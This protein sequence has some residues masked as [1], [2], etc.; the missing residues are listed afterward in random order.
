MNILVFGHTGFLGDKFL[1]FLNNTY[2]GT[3]VIGISIEK[4]GSKYFHIDLEE[5]SNFS[6]PIDIDNDFD[7]VFNFVHSQNSKNVFSAEKELAGNIVDFIETKKIN[8]PL[9]MLR[10]VG[11]ESDHIRS[12]VAFAEIIK[13]RLKN[14]II[15]IRAGIIEEEGSVSYEIP[16]RVLKQTR[17]IPRFPWMDNKV[18]LIKMSDLLDVFSNIIDGREK[19]NL[20]TPKHRTMTYK[21]YIK[22]IAY[23]KRI[24]V[25]FIKMPFNDFIVTPFLVKLL[26]GFDHN[27][28]KNLMNTLKND[29]VL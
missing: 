22:E 1:E 21:E 3:K 4:T 26:T 10:S 6:D 25:D 19:S 13:K 23:E 14:R 27:I 11:K 28:V 29:S 24:K 17:F 16:Y 15:E 2:K 20:V 12:R 5:F 8:A 7:F 18:S 9:V